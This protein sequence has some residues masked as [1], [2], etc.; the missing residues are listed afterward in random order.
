[1]A[2][3]SVVNKKLLLLS[4]VLGV[5]AVILFIVYD[6][7]KEERL[8][9][10]TV[11]VLK[12]TRNL[13][14]DEEIRPGDVADVEISVRDMEAIQG[15]VRW[16]ERHLVAEGSHVNRRVSK[17]DYIRYGQIIEIDTSLPSSAVRVGW[18]GI[19]L[20]VDPYKSPGNML[21]IGDR[22]DV[23]GMVSIRGKPPRNHIL[24]Q[25]LRVLAIGGESENPQEQIGSAQARRY[26]PRRRVYRS[27][28]VEVTEEVAVQL[29]DLLPRVQGKPWLL[30]RNPTDR[31]AKFDNKLNPD[32]LEVLSQPLPDTMY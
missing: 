9:G 4:L 5:V 26:N 22:V 8:R 12:W 11:R 24:I 6:S 1:M 2:E 15:V 13:G 21:S 16:S 27:V 17:G 32:V 23:M 30:I 7:L 31:K 10:P 18:R 3:Q 19:P 29:G 25:N 20:Q 14:P 28:M